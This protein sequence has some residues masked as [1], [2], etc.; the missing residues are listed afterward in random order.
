VLVYY[1]STTY[2][3]DANY[4]AP[5]LPDFSVRREQTTSKEDGCQDAENKHWDAVPLAVKG[6]GSPVS[7]NMN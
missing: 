6:L 4:P 1:L 3:V 2:P 7:V 5:P